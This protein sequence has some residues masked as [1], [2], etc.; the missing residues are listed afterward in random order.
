MIQI[1]FVAEQEGGEIGRQTQVGEFLEE[2][3]GFLKATLTRH[4]VDH[5]K[6]LA[7]SYV[8]VQATVLLK[9]FGTDAPSVTRAVR[10][11]YR[12]LTRTYTFT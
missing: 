8:R 11:E 7:P 10:Y 9:Q 5:D 1:S 4:A 12:N 6:G 3:P 2:S